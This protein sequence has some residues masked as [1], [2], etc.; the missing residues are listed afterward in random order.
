MD[1]YCPKKIFVL[2][3]IIKRICKGANVAEEKEFSNVNCPKGYGSIYWVIPSSSTTAWC[4]ISGSGNCLDCCVIAKK[5][6]GTNCQVKK[7]KH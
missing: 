6:V 2:K 5:E 7:K 1:G 4:P 3:F